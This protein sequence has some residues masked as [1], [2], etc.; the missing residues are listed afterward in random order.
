MGTP[1]LSRSSAKNGN[2]SSSPPPRLLL[3]LVRLALSDEG[4]LT[5]PSPTW[6]AMSLRAE[7]ISSACA[8]PSSAQ[9]PATS[10]SGRLLPKRAA[11]TATVALGAGSTFMAGDHAPALFRGQRP[12]QRDEC[13][14]RPEIVA[15][16]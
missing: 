9:G 14:V 3:A 4:F 6:P 2:A 13:L 16:C 11:P 5:R 10:T 12:A 15:A 7:T 1:S 8:R